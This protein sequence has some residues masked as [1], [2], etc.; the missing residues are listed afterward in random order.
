[1][2]LILSDGV[3]NK[4]IDDVVDWIHYYHGKCIRINSNSILDSTAPV[5][6]S[7]S[8]NFSFFGKNNHLSIALDEIN[9]IWNWRWYDYGLNNSK[10]YNN[11]D[12]YRYLNDEL[13]TLYYFFKDLTV[14]KFWWGE[15]YV[16]K[17]KALQISQKYGV[18]IPETF[19]TKSK[20]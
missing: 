19:V 12:I 20:K 17:I 16:N 15:K 18:N 4:S 7:S 13:N 8:N 14:R 2:I 11:I 5:S 1:M 10:W 3:S 6:L 9:V